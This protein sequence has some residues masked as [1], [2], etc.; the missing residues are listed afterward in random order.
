MSTRLI[1]I[2]YAA[3]GRRVGM[4]ELRLAQAT[5]TQPGDPMLNIDR[6]AF[7]TYLGGSAAVAPP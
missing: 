5:A 3:D 2:H 6:R 7:F 1:S 4:D